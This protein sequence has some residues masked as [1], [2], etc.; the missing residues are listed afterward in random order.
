M[1]SFQ[2]KVIRGSGEGQIVPVGSGDIVSIGRSRHSNNQ[3]VLSELDV[4]ARH[5]MVRMDKD[6]VWLEVLSDKV[7]EVE[8]HPLQRGDRIPLYNG[9]KV[10]L[11]KMVSFVLEEADVPEAQKQT[12][13][14]PQAFP[15]APSAPP[16]Q[17][18]PSAPSVPPQPAVVPSPSNDDVNDDT[19]T[20]EFQARIFQF[21]GTAAGDAP[22]GEFQPRI[23]SAGGGVPAPAPSVPPPGPTPNGSETAFQPTYSTMPAAATPE[24]AEEDGNQTRESEFE[25]R[26]AS[27]DELE[28]VKK[29][30][31][32]KRRRKAILLG[33]AV[34]LFLGI[35]CSLYFWLRPKD[36]S[37]MTWPDDLNLPDAKS[38]IVFRDYIGLVFPSTLNYKV[39]EDAVEVF[40][41][42]GTK[43]DI[44]VHIQ[45]FAWD[46]PAGLQMN[47]K[48]AFSQYRKA[49][50]AEDANLHF[51]KN[52][53]NERSLFL[54][55]KVKFSAGVP[56]SYESFTR[57]LGNESYFGY[58]VFFRYQAMN[59]AYWVEAPEATRAKTGEYLEYMLPSMFRVANDITVIHW[60]GSSKYRK[61]SGIRDDLEDARIALHG[62]SPFEFPSIY[63]YIHSAL[64]KAYLA[65]DQESLKT[66]RDLLY[67]LR[68][69]QAEE[70]NNMKLAYDSA[71]RD[72]GNKNK[73]RENYN[74]VFPGDEL[75]D[76]DYRCGLFK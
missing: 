62:K 31:Q 39:S 23:L 65:D 56:V 60:E 19:P 20:V 8:G 71:T 11:G 69:A 3:I 44:P 10:N 40:T 43:R 22:T 76:T 18:F 36:D 29:K 38:A 55:E 25:T 50:E 70:F 14:P 4:S 75:G 1:S 35:S 48:D 9:Q 30:Y 6:G 66:A 63:Y 42:F 49:K 24:K 67:S 37:E 51:D 68:Q 2:I 52:D 61:T 21:P 46:D 73:I 58:L 33:I 57:K 41:A 13:P 16:P 74:A 59:V 32:S 47:R 28:I 12:P 72:A 26:Y 7:T 5:C 53:K 45:V 15:S 34:T 64:I 27:F 17:A 54:N